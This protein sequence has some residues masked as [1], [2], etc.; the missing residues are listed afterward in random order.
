MLQWFAELSFP[1]FLALLSAANVLMYVG[2]W[3]AVSI[4]QRVFRSRML[5]AAEAKPTRREYVLSFV[6]VLINIAVGVPGWFF[7][8]AHAIDLRDSGPAFVALDLLLL[9][10][11]FD[12]AMYALHRLMHQGPLYRFIHSKHHDHVDVNGIS[13]YVMNPAESLGFGALLIVFLMLHP[14]NLYA[15]LGFLTLNWAYGTMGHSGIPIRSALLRWLVGD[16]E[17]HHRH[18]ARLRGNFGFYTPLWDRLFGT[19]L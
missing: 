15:L 3:A 4:L 9:L 10:I 14:T 11:Y 18:H 1:A 7:W 19:G 8:K 13:L 6:I 16:T 12:F 5:N 2:S 17:F